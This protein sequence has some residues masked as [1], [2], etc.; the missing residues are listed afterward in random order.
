M[1]LWYKRYP[2]N[3]LDG[4]RGLTL[5]ETGAYNI[6]LDLIYDRNGN[7]PD[8]DRFIAGWLRCAVQRWRR[9]KQRLVELGKLI[10]K[11]GLLTNARADKE[12]TTYEELRKCSQRAG[13]ASAEKRNK[14]NETESTVVKPLKTQ[15]EKE[16][17][18]D[19]TVVVL[20]CATRGQSKP[21]N[22]QGFTNSDGTVS[23]TSAELIRIEIDFPHLVDPL[24]QITH[25]AESTWMDRLI[26]QGRKR[27]IVAKLR[28]DNNKLAAKVPKQTP[29]QKAVVQ[30]ATD[31]KVAEQERRLAVR[32]RIIGGGRA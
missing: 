5:E 29:Q 16:E 4:M 30:A 14:N 25:L 24:G 22:Q 18:Q 1:T 13:K 11:N 15:N 7:L 23:F 9:I 20:D 6:I 21:E 27:A 10:I 28:K 8:D 19:S 17:K 26:P 32:N 3:A 31:H 12:L 2:Q